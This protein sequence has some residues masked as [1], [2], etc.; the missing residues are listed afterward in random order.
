VKEDTIRSGR[1]FRVPVDQG[2]GK[3]PLSPGVFVSDRPRTAAKKAGV[4]VPD[5]QR[6]GLH[7]LR[8]SLSSYLVLTAKVDPKTA[9]E[10][11]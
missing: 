9:Q 4:H 8:H 7:S 2:S 3:V 1:G 6:F 10:F 11:L 5:G